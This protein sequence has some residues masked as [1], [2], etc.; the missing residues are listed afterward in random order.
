MACF[1]RRLLE[2]TSERLLK[3]CLQSPRRPKRNARRVRGAR[4]PSPR[5]KQCAAFVKSGC[6]GQIQ[7]DHA[8]GNASRTQARLLAAGLKMAR[9]IDSAIGRDG[10]FCNKKSV[11]AT[12]KQTAAKLSPG[13]D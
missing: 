9:G 5:P 6:Q 13:R 11:Q 8:S 7:G 1:S 2:D 12:S 3:R 4:K 10:S